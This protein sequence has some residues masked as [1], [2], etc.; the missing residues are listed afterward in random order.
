MPSSPPG[1]KGNRRHGEK[2]T[3]RE[4]EEERTKRDEENERTK[5]TTK[6][7]CGERGVYQ[8]PTHP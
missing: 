7:S 2:E 3:R 6:P 5:R 4:G 1:K 8:N